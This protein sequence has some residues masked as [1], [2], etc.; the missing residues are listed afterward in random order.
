MEKKNI[1]LNLSD[2]EASHI[3]DS[4]FVGLSSCDWGLDCDI[5]KMRANILQQLVDQGFRTGHNYR[6][7]KRHWGINDS[8]HEY[9]K[10]LQSQKSLE[11]E[12]V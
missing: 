9:Q 8:H 1:Q 5:C 2:R 3:T 10:W 7:L 4:L 6:D 11:K 12:E